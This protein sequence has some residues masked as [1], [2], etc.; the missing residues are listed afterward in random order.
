MTAKHLLEYGKKNFKYEINSYFHVEP[1]K[2]KS[3]TKLWKK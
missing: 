2:Q 3:L 1:K